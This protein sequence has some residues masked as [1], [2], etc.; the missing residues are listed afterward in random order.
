MSATVANVLFW[1][2]G[3]VIGLIVATMLGATLVPLAVGAV[4]AWLIHS[5]LVYQFGRSGPS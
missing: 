1:I 3:I 2:V 5:L 4:I